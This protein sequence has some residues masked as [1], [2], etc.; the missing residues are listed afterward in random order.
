MVAKIDP[1]SQP[2][3]VVAKIEPLLQAVSEEKV[4]T[5]KLSSWGQVLISYVVLMA[6]AGF[7]FIATSKSKKRGDLDKLITTEP[8]PS[9]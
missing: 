2:A 5:I 3:T 7:Y 4:A 1:L 9:G 6:F 8:T